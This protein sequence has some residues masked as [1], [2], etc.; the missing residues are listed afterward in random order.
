MIRLANARPESQF[1]FDAC[2]FGTGGP[3]GQSRSAVTPAAYHLT[4][5][6]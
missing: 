4:H 6:W 3:R 5:Y 1:R 2:L